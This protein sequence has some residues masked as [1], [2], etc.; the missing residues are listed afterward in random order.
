MDEALEADPKSSA[1]E[2]ES[3]MTLILISKHFVPTSAPLER[4][5]C[6]IISSEFFEL[7]SVPK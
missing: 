6:L 3:Q 1:W 5:Q 7:C 4:P 2:A